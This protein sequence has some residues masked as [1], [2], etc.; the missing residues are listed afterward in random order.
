MNP[1]GFL[2]LNNDDD[3]GNGTPD[4]D[5][6]GPVVGEDDLKPLTISLGPTATGTGTGTVT[7]SCV[8]EC[9]RIRVYQ[10]PDRSGELFLPFSWA[11]AGQPF[12]V[13]LY[14]EGI[15]TSVSAADVL[16]KAEF[17]GSN[18][19]QDFSRVTVYHVKEVV[20]ETRADS[21]ILALDDDTVNNGGK[22]I[23]PGKLSPADTPDPPDLRRQVDL[24]A[25]I[26][27][28]VPGLACES[29]YFKV[30]DVDDPF[31][32][33]NPAMPN[34]SLIDDDF[35]GPDNRPTPEAPVSLTGTIDPSGKA[36]VTF[37]VSMQ[38]GNNYRAG[39]SCLSDAPT[40]TTQIKADSV[41]FEPGHGDFAGYKT[42][43]T[44]SKM[45]TVW[46]KLH[47][48]LAAMQRPTFLQNTWSGNWTAAAAFPG[49]SNWII[50]D[51]KDL[52]VNNNQLENGWIQIQGTG[53][54]GLPSFRVLESLDG[55]GNDTITASMP[56]GIA[57][58]GGV[59]SGTF[60]VSD[61]DLSDQVL[62]DAGVAAPGA[63]G[64]FG[65][66]VTR[67][68]IPL[69][70]SLPFPDTQGV[71]TLYAPA[72][73]LPVVDG[74]N[75]GVVPFVQNLPD[76]FT[77]GY[78]DSFG[79]IRS[80]GNPIS[81]PSF[82]TALLGT[83]FQSDMDE[84]ADPENLLTKGASPHANGSTDAGPR[85]GIAV[86]FLETIDDGGGV[87]EF[88]II[89]HELAHTLGVPHDEPGTGGIME[90]YPQG[91]PVFLPPN[92]KTLR[93]YVEP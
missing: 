59:T 66:D 75:T 79:S 46:R 26:E 68:G 13:T 40:D 12:I 64:S 52:P 32:Q 20:W 80:P 6:A 30:W 49:T 91:A 29:V 14:V 2:C 15:D 77:N 4:K 21:G 54:A 44:W 45:L 65:A 73:V 83:G 60:I 87:T 31:N 48:E 11:P 86:V 17:A 19:C 16:L 67:F 35:D 56:G 63:P 53:L 28:A 85:T 38:P 3:D 72:Y 82:W 51:I 23:Y 36:R 42:P 25:T 69:G 88:R 33:N 93:K 58:L 90:K 1:G 92:L 24:V 76:V 22:R 61:D 71:D 5:Q 37:T 34:V 89:A 50:F 47:L 74:L 18:T 10:N 81:T 57:T 9:G 43:L 78:F 62:F 8:T 39:A 7:L 55:F 84:D 70:P 41:S 27:P